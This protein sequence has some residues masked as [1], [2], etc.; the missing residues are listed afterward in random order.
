[1]KTAQLIEQRSVLVA[2]MRSLTDAPSGTAGDLSEAQAS[3]F[4]EL[5]S[6]METIDKSIER[7]RF[8]DEADRRSAGTPIGEGDANFDREVR[9]F[10]L[11]RAIAAQAGLSGIDAG[12][13]REISA[14]LAKRS[15]ISAQGFL[16]P[17]AVFEQRVLTTTTPAAGP[18]S[19]LIQTDLRGDLF[20]DRL[21]ASLVTGRLGATV[22]N[23]LQGNVDIPRLKASAS[24]GWVAENAPL[25]PSDHQ[26]DKVA[27]T[28]KHVGAITE[29]SRN[30]LQQ[31]SVDIEQLVRNDF[32]AILAEA[33]DR[34]ALNGS[35]TGAEPRGVLNVAGIGNV[36][37]G[38][39]GAAMTIDTAADLMGAVQQLDVANNA[40]GFATTPKVQTAAL[41]LKD[42]NARPYDANTIW[43]NENVLFSNVV[44]S[45]LTKGSGTN[46]SAA[47]YGNWSDLLIG[48][49]SA[50][51]LLVNPYEST[52]YAKGN[53]QIRAML[54][55]DIAVRY[56]Q[57]FAAAK[58]IAA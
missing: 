18:G 22:L 51:D 31:P 19:N 10:S 11:V 24:T 42:N 53:V 49:W 46:L 14:E 17:T 40:R 8:V 30:M 29:L 21:R 5:R 7:A 6:R 35:G 33:M 27:M 34:A 26:F 20:I 39:N 1:V 9:S 12:R 52:A 45:S 13:E 23:G 3:K 38:T 32:A 25:T 56:A 57:S 4:D 48:Y 50:F 43:K 16:V 28:P 55:A 54:T 2:E 58:D 37:L 47:I 15:G 36:A 44:P 41:K